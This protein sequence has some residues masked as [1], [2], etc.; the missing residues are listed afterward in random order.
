M[1][2]I[3]IYAQSLI[4][5]KFDLNKQEWFTIMF[6]LIVLYYLINKGYLKHI[7]DFRLLRIV[8]YIVI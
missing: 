1:V 6:N 2:E 8:L 5:K 7:G 4:E 3:K